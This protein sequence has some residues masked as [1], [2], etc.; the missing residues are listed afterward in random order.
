MNLFSL[1]DG[2]KESRFNTPPVVKEMISRQKIMKR[3]H[4]LLG[5]Y[6][7]G[8]PLDDFRHQLQRLSCVPLKDFETLPSG[9]VCRIAFIIE[10]VVVENFSKVAAQIRHLDDW[11][12]ARAL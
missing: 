4:E 12:W 7:N 2:E 11:R 10:G 8:H 5:I 3:E 1:I 9:S 6:L